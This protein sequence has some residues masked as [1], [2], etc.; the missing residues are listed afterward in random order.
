MKEER[1]MLGELATL[2]LG[3]CAIESLRLL[4]IE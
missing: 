3:E 4:L 1:I 2:A